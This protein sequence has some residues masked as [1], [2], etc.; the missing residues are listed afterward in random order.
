MATSSVR[1]QVFYRGQV[2]GVGFR[3]TTQHIARNHPVG[4]FV[5]NLANGQVE[6]VVEGSEADVGRFL[7]AVAARMDEYVTGT[8]V[9]EATP[10]GEFSGF[11]I[12]Q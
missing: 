9:I 5:R 11:D 6:L 10:T 7:A 2:Q 4:G 12:R 8:E 1:R 3:Y